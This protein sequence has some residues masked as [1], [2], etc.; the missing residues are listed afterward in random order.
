MELSLAPS[1]FNETEVV[2]VDLS[3]DADLVIETLR[4]WGCIYVG[5]VLLFCFLRQRYNRFYN[6]RSWVTKFECQLAKQEYSFFSWIWKVYEVT[7]E[8][9]FHERGLDILCFIRAMRFGIKLGA[10]GT[11]NSFWL[12]PIYATA[13]DSEET[14]YIQD[15]FVQISIAN[16]PESSPR[17]FAVILAAYLTFFTTMY[18]IIQELKW[19]TK[20]RH[21]FLSQ[22]I[23]RN[24][25][26]YVSGIPKAYR[27]NFKLA[28]YFRSCISD[29]SILEVHVAMDIPELEGKQA[30]R[31]TVI[32]KLEHTMALE[33]RTGKPEMV[34]R[35]QDGM[36][37]VGLRSML[38]EELTTLNRD[39]PRTIN[40]ISAQNDQMRSRLLSLSERHMKSRRRGLLTMDGLSQEDLEDMEVISPSRFRHQ[41]MRGG[42]PQSVPESS[43]ESDVDPSM[44]SAH[45]YP[46]SLQSTDHNNPS[47]GAII[48]SLAFEGKYNEE[49]ES[50]VDIENPE[51]VE[52]N[53]IGLGSDQEHVVLSDHDSSEGGDLDLLPMSRKPT[54]L[55]R[56]TTSSSTMGK[57]IATGVS[58]VSEVGH[59]IMR[60]TKVV[61]SIAKDEGARLGKTAHLIGKNIVSSGGAVVPALLN[62]KQG[63]PRD[64]GFV[65]F[66]TLFAAQIAL[67]MLHHPKPYSMKAA[68]APHPGAIFWRNV[69]LPKRSRRTGTLLSLGSTMVLCFFWTIPVT[70]VSSLA[71]VGA[72]KEA[73]PKFDEW[74][75]GRYWI[76]TMLEQFAPLLLLLMNEAIL[77]L[78]LRLFSTWEGFISS[79]VLEASL[80]S[81]LGIF[82]VR[83][84]SGLLVHSASSHA[85]PARLS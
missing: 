42:F 31:E 9:I 16:L 39:I 82:M 21:V 76:E 38:E 48:A 32:R 11:L 58:G 30:R 56:D 52:L 62:K 63:T 69:G 54:N 74:L 22:R 46:D 50:S 26:V 83:S 64:A 5:A 60:G 12:I 77:P 43:D 6:I 66:R 7:E 84:S 13:K 85:H 10:L 71:E 24:Y 19:Y 2:I 29:E 45:Q 18:L 14:D 23:P 59:A 75:Q 25:T 8:E 33:Q 79:A 4:L 44:K 78:V 36:E 72:L 65:T 80:Y 3:N 57:V 15:R 20:W 61:S 55:E 17:F 49:D 34:V 73:M 47:N 37:R 28:S 35:L 27:S 68:E 70:F 81:K 53:S 67:Q 51:A 40:E 41:S 1:V